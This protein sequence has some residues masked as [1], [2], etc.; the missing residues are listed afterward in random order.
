MKNKLLLATLIF[1][2]SLTS[3]GQVSI[4]V[5]DRSA[6]PAAALDVFSTEKGLLLPRMTE[7]Q[8]DEI[9]NIEETVDGV[10]A[11]FLM[12]VNTD[13]KCVEIWVD[14]YWQ[15]LWCSE[16]GP[17]ENPCEGVT[18]P[19]GF[20][21]VESAGYC[22]LDR[23]LGAIGIPET[24]DDPDGFGY[25]F[26]WG[27]AADGHQ[28]RTSGTTTT[29][30]T[31]VNP[32]HSDFIIGEA[33]WHTPFDETLWQ[34]ESGTNNPCPNGWR[35][36]TQD[37]M[38]AEQETW[39]SDPDPVQCNSDDAFGSPLKWTTNCS[40]RPDNGEIDKCDRGWYWL[41]DVIDGDRPSYLCLLDTW[42]S[43][44]RAAASARGYA[45]RC[46]AD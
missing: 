36:P 34:G 20:G 10:D 8:R 22:W 43:I 45:V 13:S 18:P 32:P 16:L 29:Q 25:S 1:A 7:D 6:H 39:C 33:Q 44:T 11:E 26:Q 38:E 23:N 15:E 17:V 3:F 28:V 24:K 35:L 4:S 46:I 31:T 40:R 9:S 37:E 2:Y 42:S 27:R 14:G 30:S 12:I 41:S 21:I 5:E 19:D